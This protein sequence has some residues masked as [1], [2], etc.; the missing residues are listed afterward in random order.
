[1][2]AGGQLFSALLGLGGLA[3]LA[4]LLFWTAHVERDDCDECGR[5]E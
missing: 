4:A 1:M 5:E 3:A 2:I